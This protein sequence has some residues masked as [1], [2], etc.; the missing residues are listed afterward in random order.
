MQFAESEKELNWVSKTIMNTII[1]I[2][3][4]F[5]SIEGLEEFLLQFKHRKTIPTFEDLQDLRKQLVEAEK[6]RDKQSE[7]D[8]ERFKRMFD[9]VGKKANSEDETG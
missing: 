7:R 1:P 3:D 9:E 4:I 5:G 2:A 6:K 8:F